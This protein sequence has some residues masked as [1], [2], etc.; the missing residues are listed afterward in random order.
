MNHE[1]NR[2]WDAV[3]SWSISSPRSNR[4]L[5]LFILILF[6]G[7]AIAN[8]SGQSLEKKNVLIVT[9][10]GH[11]HPLSSNMTDQIIGELRAMPNRQVE[12]Y[13]EDLDLIFP[14][15]GPS[16][17][18]VRA[19]LARKYG[20]YRLDVVVAVGPDTVDFLSNAGR[21]LFPGVPIV[22]CGTSA[23]Q[24][25]SPKL[26][27]RFTGTWVKLEPEKTL[28]L[29]LRLFPETREVFVVGGSSGFD[30]TANSLANEAIGSVR[31]K[32]GI[33]DLTEME[34]GALIKRL[35]DLPEHS[36][37]MYTSFFQDAAG[38]KYLNA[39]RALPTI[40]AASNGPDFGMSDTYLGHGVVGGFV[41]PFA[42]QAK[43]T[44]QIIAE[45]LDGKKAQELPM[46]TIPG[47]Y[48]FDWHELQSWHISEKILPAGS[49]VLFREPTVWERTRWIWVSSIL[50]ILGLSLLTVYLSYSRKLLK[51]AQNRQSQLSGML[52][53]AEEKE[54]SRVAT[55]LH[56][57]FSQRLALLALELENT[58]ETL[59]PSAREANRQLH[60]L[61]NSVS[62]LGADLHTLSH[63]LH[64]STLERLGLVQGVSAFCKEF[65][66]LHGVQV[67]FT[68]NE[69][70]KAVPPE[71][72]LCL[73]RIVQEGLRNVHAHSGAA[74][75]QVGVH[76]DGRKLRIFIS[77]QGSGFDEPK[78]QNREGLGLLSME[79]R[80]SHLGGQFKIHSQTGKGTRLEAWVP[81]DPHAVRGSS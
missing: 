42:K 41:M 14:G 45:L 72:A 48:M 55:E 44:S 1:S 68:H 56:D 67:E 3:W 25:G 61:V 54:R 58:A 81:L 60:E 65:Q 36:I 15:D 10:V 37:V 47:L 74:K 33:H 18:E 53:S 51:I 21:G 26:D 24:L 50:I 75:A 7:F 35:Q 78:V 66:A 49:V 77:D 62:E 12:F 79:E 43:I 59:P 32:A 22:V 46:A 39:T 4:H 28:E 40:A 6:E 70:P 23:N 8:A 27:S 69:I 20:R 30:K 38:E 19:W 52:I 71:T 9:E 73:F 80:A 31:T 2:R 16:R 5:V 64:S 63:R 29:A 57:D 11:S 76:R 17:E 13:V 34:L